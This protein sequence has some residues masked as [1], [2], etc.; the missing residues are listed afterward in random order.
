MHDRY[1]FAAD[2]FSILLAFSNYR[3]WPIPLALQLS[4][5]L[6]YSFI[7][8]LSLTGSIWTTM[9]PVAALL[10]T[11]TVGCLVY[12]YWKACRGEVPAGRQEM[13]E[14]SVALAAIG[15]VA[16]IWIGVAL[17][18]RY[19]AARICAGGSRELCSWELN[20]N[21]LNA[22][23]LQRLLFFAV[24]A[25]GYWTARRMTRQLLARPK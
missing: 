20:P 6:A 24:L 11:A 12:L 1:F 10:N 16:S 21:L 5:L 25:G 3:L 22:N 18:T 17:V 15:A 8:S 14:F 7:I 19:A 2:I 9:I 23:L 13:T 4:S